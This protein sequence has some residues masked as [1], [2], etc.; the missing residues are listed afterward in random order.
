MTNEEAVLQIA[1]A[2]ADAEHVANTTCD[3]FRDAK[4]AFEQLASNEGVSTLEAL[5][6][7]HEM[8]T[9]ATEFRAKLYGLHSRLTVR[10]TDLGFEA[11]LP[12]MRSGTGR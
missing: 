3:A 11:M 12:A 9:I 8:E 6:M 1:T 7:A 10:A 5:A 2:F 4:G